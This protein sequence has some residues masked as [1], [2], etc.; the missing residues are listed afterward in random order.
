MQ[1]TYRTTSLSPS[2]T[3][4]RPAGRRFDANGSAG[5]VDV[6]PFV[7][8][9]LALDEAGEAFRVLADRSGLKV[10]VEPQPEARA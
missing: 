10:V 2:R 8:H 5:R 9:R 7:S 1:L 4:P 6:R 3:S